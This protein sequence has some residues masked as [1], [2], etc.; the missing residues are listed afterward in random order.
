MPDRNYLA[1]LGVVIVWIEE[2]DFRVTLR[3]RTS[4]RALY[5]GSKVTSPIDYSFYY[6]RYLGYLV[7]S[8]IYAYVPTSDILGCRRRTVVRLGR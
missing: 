1:Y 8:K 5:L 4:I 2:S 6:R 7:L 3:R